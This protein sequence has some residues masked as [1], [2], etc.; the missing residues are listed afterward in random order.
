MSSPVFKACI[1]GYKPLLSGALV[2]ALLSSAAHAGKWPGAAGGEASGPQ[3]ELLLTFDDGP[4]ENYTES[5]LDTLDAHHL[6]GLFFWTG[7]RVTNERNGLTKRLALVERAVRTGH[8]IGNHTSTHAK[9]C[10]VEALDAE[11]EIDENRKLYETLSGLPMILFRVPYGARCKRLDGMLA[12]RDT[13]HLHWDLDPQE[14]RHQSSDL[15]FQ[16]VT[17]RLS[18]L[19][20]GKRAILLMHDTQPVTAKVL[21]KILEWIEEENQRRAEAIKASLDPDH[22]KRRNDRELKQPIRIMTASEFV[23]ERYPVP[24]LTFARTS[25]L[26]AARALRTA[27][28]QVVPSL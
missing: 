23:E 17:R 18:R 25:L 13:K 22:N 7:H 16:Y 8:L 6:Q 21:P 20:N 15:A 19:A 1:H 5:I 2:L 4:H 11:Q 14:F 3:P 28:I 24:L 10:T 27:T 9:L 12:D 26:E